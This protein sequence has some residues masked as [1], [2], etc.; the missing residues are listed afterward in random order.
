[1]KNRIIALALCAGMLLLGGC[2]S[3]DEAGAGSG[4]TSETNGGQA[5][6]SPS[7][8]EQAQP[9]EDT[10]TSF[11]KLF[12]D[13]PLLVQ[14]P[15]GY[16]WGY[17]DATGNYV[18]EP[19]FNLAYEFQENGLALVN[20]LETKMW[21]YINTSGEYV[22][23]PQ[24][25]DATQFDENGYASVVVAQTKCGGIIN[26]SGEY[27]IEPEHYGGIGSLPKDTLYWNVS[28]TRGLNYN[29]GS[30]RTNSRQETVKG[31]GRLLPEARPTEKLYAHRHGDEYGTT[32]QRPA[33]A[34]VVGRI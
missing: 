34:Q 9:S 19:K 28:L 3:H 16:G 26:E 25:S 8:T 27:V 1:M 4:D 14:D 18:I 10:R 13:G 24:F 7:T 29:Y 33:P 5:V 17:I 30:Y 15:D 31:T 12:N 11:E 22:I 6:N 32:H 2:A 21:G 23:E 20:D